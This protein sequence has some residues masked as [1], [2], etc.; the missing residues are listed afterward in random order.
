MSRNS[1]QWGTQQEYSHTNLTATHLLPVPA[2]QNRAK[3]PSH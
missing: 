2:T 3:E 1:L